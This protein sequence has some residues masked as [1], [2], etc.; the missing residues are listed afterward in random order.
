MKAITMWTNQLNQNWNYYRFD[1]LGKFLARK[2]SFAELVRRIIEAFVIPG[3]I[4]GWTVRSRP[5]QNAKGFVQDMA[6]QTLSSIPLIGSYLAGIIK[7]YSADADL[8]TLTALEK[9]QRIAYQVNRKQWQKAIQTT[10]ELIGFLVGAPV[11]QPKRTIESICDLA[12]GESDDWLRLIWGQYAREKEVR[13]TLEINRDNRAE[14]HFK[15]KW[16]ELMP[17]QKAWLK[18]R[19]PEAREEKKE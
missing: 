17:E 12:T 4:I 16:D 19:Y 14:E 9:A 10:P 7:G 1:C 15:K 6:A 13:A 2:I 11:V 8:I 5:A 3:L 18:E